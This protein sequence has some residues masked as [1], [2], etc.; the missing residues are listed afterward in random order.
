MFCFREGKMGTELASCMLDNSTTK[1]SLKTIFNAGRRARG[2]VKRDA[3]MVYPGRG[4]QYKFTG[5]SCYD[6]GRDFGKD[7]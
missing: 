6:S 7:L 1:P 5:Q 4:G 2:G 3:S